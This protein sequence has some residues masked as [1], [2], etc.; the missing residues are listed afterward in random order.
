MEIVYSN[1][2][3]T[4]LMILGCLLLLT[5]CNSNQEKEQLDEQSKSSKQEDAV[6]EIT[7]PHTYVDSR[8]KEITLTEKPE[9]I[10]SVT[11][12]VTENLLALERPPIAADTVAMMSE[13]ASM[14]DYF[15]KYTIEDL[16]DMNSNLEKLLA[17]QPDLILATHY[18]E[19]VLDQ[20]EKI[21]P[22][23]VFDGDALFSNWVESLREVG[24]ALNETEAAESFISE[25]MSIVDNGKE[26]LKDT[27][28]GTIGF[29]RLVNKD[30]YLFDQ[31]Q[32]AMYY[33]STKGL[34]LQVPPNWPKETGTIQ[35]ESLPDI[36][37]DH[38]FVSSGEDPVLFDELKESSV[39]QGLIASQK[40][41]VHA[42]DLSGLTGGAL[43]T[44]YGV[45]TILS[46]LQ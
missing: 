16:G 4:F 1:F 15:D 13:W 42:I 36:N 21:A 43:A 37:P 5:A 24:K 6:T 35:L 34:G 41:Q 30:M 23:I 38:L 3:R 18:N 46:A 29:M 31:N 45:E 2:R 32:L 33:D 8:G 9:R 40:N 39:W 7:W 25:T 10:A 19:E 27:N 17:M 12:M 44:R 28:I 26:Q 11:W 20:L 22:V 14:K